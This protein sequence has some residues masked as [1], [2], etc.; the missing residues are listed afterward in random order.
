LTACRA[1]AITLDVF[2]W[3]ANA[4]FV[5]NDV[6][7]VIVVVFSV[8]SGSATFA[9]APV[10]VAAIALTFTHLTHLET[11]VLIV[12]DRIVRESTQ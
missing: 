9:I 4:F 3:D 5:E 10:L 8:S 12:E 6:A 11:V 1:R 7:I 2:D